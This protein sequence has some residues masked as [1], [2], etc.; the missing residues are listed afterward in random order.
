MHIICHSYLSL[1]CQITPL[2]GARTATACHMLACSRRCSRAARKD[3]G[4]GRAR[5]CCAARLMRRSTG[6]PPGSL[7]EETL[8]GRP[9]ATASSVASFE[10][11]K[12]SLPITEES[13]SWFIPRP[14]SV[15]SRGSGV[16]LGVVPSATYTQRSKHRET[17]P[18]S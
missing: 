11:S 16:A 12:C 15:E 6:R 3:A 18:V 1:I 10:R 2:A 14:N 4:K 5:G 7:L 13:Q 9:A 8:Q 17:H